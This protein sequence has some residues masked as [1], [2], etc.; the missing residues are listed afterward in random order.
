MQLPWQTNWSVPRGQAGNT[1]VMETVHW[2]LFALRVETPRLMLR[3]A[4]DDDAVALAELAG[5]GVHDPNLMPFSVPWT[6]VPPP[7]LQ[8]NTLQFVWSLR[9]QWA[10][11]NWHLQM[12]VVVD[13]DVVGVQA[14]S[15]E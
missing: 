14:M 13:D 3:Y 10:P 9:A 8:R 12:A 6:D 15:A 2:P 5:R 7:A 1:V 11:E 4:D